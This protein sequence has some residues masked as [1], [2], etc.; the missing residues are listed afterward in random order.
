MVITEKKNTFYQRKNSMCQTENCLKINGKII[1]Q[2]LKINKSPF[3]SR[4]IEFQLN[5]DSIPNSNDPK[6][7]K[8]ILSGLTIGARDHNEFH[9]SN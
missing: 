1:T 4:L 3:Y 7:I 6:A 2:P 5:I 9:L 8:A